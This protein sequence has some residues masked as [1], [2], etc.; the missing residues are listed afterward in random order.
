VSPLEATLRWYAVVLVVTLAFAPAVRWLCRWLPD[1]GSSLLVAVAPLF[2]VWPVWFAA[3]GFGFPFSTA[4]LV[5]VTLGAGI[6]GWCGMLRRG[7]VDRRWLRDLTTVQLSFLVLFGLAVWLRG[8]TPDLTG[9]EKPMEAAFLA[10]SVRAVEMPPPDPWYAGEPINYYYLGYVV[11]G[12]VARASGIP[13]TTAFNLT[14]PALFAATAVAAGGFAWNA[15]RPSTARGV[16]AVGATLG[17]GVVAVAGN[18]YAPLRLLRGGW[19]TVA[20]DW[21]DTALGV[22]WRSSRIVCDGPRQDGRCVFPSVETINEFPYFSFLL[23]DL[24]PHVIALPITVAALGLALA[25]LRAGATA[26]RSA[27]ARAAVSGA[28]V[29]SLYAVNSW[30]FPT[31]LAM[32]LGALW[33]RFRGDARSGLRV[34]AA[35]L[36]AS[37]VAW[38]PFWIRFVPPTDQSGTGATWLDR[39]PI[40]GRILDIVGLHLGERTSLGEYATIFGVPLVFALLLV[41]ATPGGWAAVGA[42]TRGWLAGLVGFVV[43]AI[44]LGAPVLALSAVGAAMTLR[45]ATGLPIGS[46]RFVASV[47]FGAGFGL[48]GVV[49]VFYLRDVFESR[50]NTLFKVYYQVWVLFSLAAA[51]TVIALWLA[52]R[53]SATGRASLATV[54]VAAVG[55]GAVYPILA[56]AQWTDRFASWQGFDGIAYARENHPGEW[57]AI[58]WLREQASPD[59]VVVEAAGCSYWPNGDLPFNRVAAYTGVP[60]IIGWGNNHQPQWRRGQPGLVREIPAREA[61]VAAIYADRDGSIADRYGADWLYVGTYERND[62][63]DLCP[64]AGP[65]PGIDRSDFPGPA[66]EEAFRSGDVVIYRR[67]GV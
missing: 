47:L 41:A 62:W 34:G 44:V 63:R 30:D 13:A 51:L 38:L 3:A 5:V 49:E 53:R 48:S 36:A 21:W 52:W 54:T 14:L 57:A 2:A 37:V 26:D 46:P 65:Y 11:W 7:P 39:I 33:L 66:W 1:R 32:L 61:D 67:T 16:A 42:A 10:S 15:L 17:G 19:E 12:A 23:G 20:A 56:T 22:G 45:L 50:M 9:T 31:Y 6:A 24:H 18:L 60:T 25:W 43:L 58:T 27:M 55:L 29:G 64:V 35:T 28:V 40:L 8:Y 4:A 59:D